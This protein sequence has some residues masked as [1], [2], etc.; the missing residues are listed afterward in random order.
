MADSQTCACPDCNCEVDT[1]NAV[2]SDG[3]A[4]CCDACASGHP[5]GIKCK[6]EDCGCGQSA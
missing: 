6:H 4:Y 2:M 1:D 5:N 3:Q